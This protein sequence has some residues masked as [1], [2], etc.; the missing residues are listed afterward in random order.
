M[1]EQALGE[2]DW[3]FQNHT[4]GWMNDLNM[5]LSCFR[6]KMSGTRAMRI[7][8]SQ[9]RDEGNRDKGRII[10]LDEYCPPL[11]V[12]RHLSFAQQVASLNMFH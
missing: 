6:T 1:V 12:G 3:H 5:L 11:A 2:L 8:K 4:E 9:E 7:S 10:T